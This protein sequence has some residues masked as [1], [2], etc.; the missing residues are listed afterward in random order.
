M[1]EAPVSSFDATT[2][3][4]PS[5]D[6]RSTVDTSRF[7]KAIFVGETA[8]TAVDCVVKNEITGSSVTFR[9]GS[10]SQILPVRTRTAVTMTGYS[11]VYLY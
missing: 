9:M 11:V 6:F 4:A 10:T 2:S 3:A 7:T 1:A 8:G 5:Y